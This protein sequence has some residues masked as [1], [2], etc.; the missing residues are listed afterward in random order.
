MKKRNI[1]ITTLIISSTLLFTG[2]SNEKKVDEQVNSQTSEIITESIVE[3]ESIKEDIVEEETIIEE[4]TTIIEEDLNKPAEEGMGPNDLP[5]PEI[6]EVQIIRPLTTTINISNLEDCTLNVGITKDSFIERDGEKYMNFMIYDY[7]LY[8][9]V[10]IS[11]LEVGSIIE[12]RGNEVEV[13]E[14]E[15]L[16]TGLIFINGGLEMGGYDLFTNENGVYFESLENDYKVFKEVGVVE[17][18][19]SPNFVFTDNMDL[20]NMGKTYTL[21]D[22]TKEDSTIDFFFNEFNTTLVIENNEIIELV[23]NYIP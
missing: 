19:V 13:K 17:L 20:D 15:R 18:K 14:L 10:D 16:D 21:E 12:L 6:D 11:T 23:R 22:L 5:T 2:C 1:L 8:D 9:L 7:D 4:E 3:E